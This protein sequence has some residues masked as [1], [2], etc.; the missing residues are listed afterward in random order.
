MILGTENGKELEMEGKKVFLGNKE[1]K[2]HHQGLGQKFE[3]YY[4]QLCF[5]V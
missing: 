5:N 1:Q 2:K 4:R 3:M